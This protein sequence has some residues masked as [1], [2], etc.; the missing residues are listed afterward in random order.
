MAKTIGKH[1]WDKNKSKIINKAVDW[2]KS[3][4]KNKG[5]IGEIVSQGLDNT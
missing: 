3:K 1:I 5:K 2:T 4:I